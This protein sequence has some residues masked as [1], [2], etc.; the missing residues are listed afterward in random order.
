M[1]GPLVTQKLHDTLSAA[2]RAGA[3]RVACSLDLDRSITNVD[4][5]VAEWIWQGQ[6]F[7]YLETCKDKTVYHW[8][9]G[10]FQPVARFTTSLIKLVPTEWGPPTFEIDGIKMLPTAHVCPYAD[11]ERK[12][13]LIQPRGKVILDTCGGLGYFAA[14][15]LRGQATQVLSYEKAADVM[16]L[17]S[18]NPW[19][20]EIGDGLT[21]T[22]GDI[23]EQIITLRDG[24][25]DAILHDP[26]RFG[27]AGELYSQVFYAHL[28]RV[29]KRKGKLFHYTGAPN[30]LTRGRDVPNEVMKRLLRAGFAAKVNGDGILAV[31]H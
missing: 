7:P 15:C 1:I 13:G 5:G 27:I 11:A 26:P 25:F 2:V 8:M 19:S 18:L 14:W 30:Q 24:S 16:W 6:R 3:P 28:A 4:L 20:P 17:R 10:A 22:Q 29:L 12:V 31:K 21:L 9:G 23:T